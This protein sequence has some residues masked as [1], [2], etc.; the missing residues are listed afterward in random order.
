M[1]K[2]GVAIALGKQT[3]KKKHGK[4]DYQDAMCILYSHVSG[5]SKA[6]EVSVQR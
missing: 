1:E 6:V 5:C 2:T 4:E 3:N